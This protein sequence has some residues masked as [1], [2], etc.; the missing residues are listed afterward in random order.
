M[1]ATLDETV[2]GEV[3]CANSS[4]SEIKGKGDVS[5]NV[6]DSDN[7][8]RNITLTDALYVPDN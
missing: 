5:F 1:F 3:K 8:V 2:T 4:V 6:L 7:I